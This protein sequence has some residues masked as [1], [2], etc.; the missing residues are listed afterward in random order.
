[1]KYSNL[2]LGQIEAIINKLGHEYGAMQFLDGKMQVVPVIPRTTKYTIQ[3]GDGRSAKELLDAGKYDTVDELIRA[4]VENGNVPMDNEGR[5][6]EVVVVYIPDRWITKEAVLE[7]F[8]ELNLELPTLEHVLRF[9]EKYPTHYRNSPPLCFIH[10]DDLTYL[11]FE[12]RGGRSAI[13]HMNA[14]GW[15]S[16]SHTFVGVF[17]KVNWERG[18]PRREAERANA[19]RDAEVTLGLR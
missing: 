9:R 5:E 10:G 1:M 14:A 12:G 6:M 17:D 11:N 7:E 2:N 3:V 15:L 13:R 18:R 19:R 8:K 4:S 16:Y